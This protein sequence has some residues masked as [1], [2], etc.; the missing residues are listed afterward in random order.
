MAL[1]LSVF[2]CC[3]F[4]LVLVDSNPTGNVLAQQRGNDNFETSALNQTLPTDRGPP[5]LHD[6]VTCVAQK[7]VNHK[8]NDIVQHTISPGN[9][10][11]CC[12]LC[13]AEPKC[14]IWVITGS[15][16]WLK[17]NCKSHNRINDHLATTHKHTQARA[18]I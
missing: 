11:A 8:Y 12:Q 10:T 5:N 13:K 2:V 15:T 3:F 6:N 14:G 9:T 18:H 7:G 17:S 4:G 1:A 16:C